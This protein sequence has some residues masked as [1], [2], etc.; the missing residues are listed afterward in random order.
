MELS[1]L[2]LN[3]GL[4][5]RRIEVVQASRLILAQSSVLLGDGNS[6]LLMNGNSV[7]EE[8]RS[9]YHKDEIQQSYKSSHRA[10]SLSSESH[11]S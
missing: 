11:L 5:E 8:L 7:T 4:P 10:K 3:G 6:V 9:E 2:S 1:E